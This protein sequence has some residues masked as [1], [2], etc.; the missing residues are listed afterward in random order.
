MYGVP[1][2]HTINSL[3]DQQ[4]RVLKDNV[5]IWCKTERIKDW[6]RLL[7]IIFIIMNSH[8]SS[9]SGHLPQQL[10]M[11]RPV[12]FLHAPYPEESYSTVGRWVREQQDK[13]DKARAML[14]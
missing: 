2:T 4:T 8:E 3:F 7:P 6:V 1:Y 9:A 14:Q 13:V 10:F 5:R 12:W 11:G